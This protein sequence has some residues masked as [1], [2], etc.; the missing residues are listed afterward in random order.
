MFKLSSVVTAVVVIVC[1]V[2][3]AVAAN[4]TVTVQ[5]AG[6]RIIASGVSPRG[7]VIFFGRSVQYQSGIPYYQ[8]H[9]AIMTDDDRDGS[10]TLTLDENVSTFSTWAVVDF[11]TGASAVVAP[12]GRAPRRIDLPP[13][14]WR[15]GVSYIDLSRDALDVL[16]VRP[17]VGAWMLGMWQGGRFDADA[18]RDS[19]LRAG[20]ASMKPIIGTNPSPPTATPRDVIVIIDPLKLDVFTRQAD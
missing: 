9:S 18:R 12:Q 4:D 13:L 11:D 5:I 1:S 16:L 20:L 8:R 17:R 10:V 3:A 19:N 14:V 7:Q 2:C 15:G 6:N